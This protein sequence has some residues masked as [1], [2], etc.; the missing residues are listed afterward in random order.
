MGIVFIKNTSATG[1]LGLWKLEESVEAL[2]QNIVLTENEYTIFKQKKTEQRKKEW[3]GVRNLLKAMIPGQPSI[4][5]DVHGSPS[6]VNSNLHIS[7]SH[8]G[9]YASLYTDSSKPVGVD[10]QKI[11]EDI[12]KGNNYFLNN[13]ELELN[14]FQEGITLNII[15]SAKEAIFKYCGLPGLDSKEDITV[16]LFNPKES[17]LIVASV[18]HGSFQEDV[19]LAYEIFDQYILTRTN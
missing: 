3:L 2:E 9:D 12:I 1:L 11:K 8:S 15:W 16:Q 18:L 14:H 5:Y 7:I 10:I 4:Q 6:L 17:G 19:A 13:K